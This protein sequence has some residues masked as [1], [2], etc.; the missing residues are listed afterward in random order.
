MHE[1]GTGTGREVDGSHEKVRME[2][3]ALLRLHHRPVCTVTVL[4]LASQFEA[5]RRLR[6]Q[7]YTDTSST[8]GAALPLERES[9]VQIGLREEGIQACFLSHPDRGSLDLLAERLPGHGDAS[10][11]A[12]RGTWHLPDVSMHVR[13]WLVWCRLLIKTLSRLLL[14]YASIYQRAALR[15]VF[16]AWSMHRGPM[17]VLSR[18]GL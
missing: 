18:M 11:P 12:L 6:I 9:G 15:G 2:R 10:R 17:R 16:S 8:E 5:R 13:G 3:A 1:G 7:Q 4:L 14:L